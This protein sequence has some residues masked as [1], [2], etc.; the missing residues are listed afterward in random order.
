MA[1][2]LELK[3]PKQ[4]SYS[5]F[6]W[7]YCDFLEFPSVKSSKIFT[8]HRIRPD[9]NFNREKVGIVLAV[10]SLFACLCPFPVNR[11]WSRQIDLHEKRSPIKIK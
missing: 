10:S 3:L 9:K 7:L 1:I 2:S 6:M 8:V 5:V 11:K 4:M